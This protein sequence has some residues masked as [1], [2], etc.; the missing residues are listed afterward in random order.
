[1]IVS[2]N[3]LADYVDLPKDPKELTERL[4]MAGL[5]HESTQPV[6]DDWAID[7]EVTSNRPD[8]MSHVGVA[9][10]IAALYQ[11]PLRL[12]EA[13][14]QAA[15]ASVQTMARVIVECPDLC[16]Q[17]V[18]RVIR[19]VT[20]G[21]SPTWLVKRLETMGVKSINNVVDITNY[22]LFE[23]G[24]PLHA[25]DFDKLHERTIRVR[26]GVRGE[27]ILAIDHRNYELDPQMCII[28]DS[29]RA[30]AIG[31]V[32]GGAETEVTYQTRNV[33]IEAAEFAPLSI[34]ATSRKLRLRTAS[35]ERFERGIDPEMVDWASRRCCALILEY[36]GGQLC[37]GAIHFRAT[38]PVRK[39]I[40]LRLNQLP[41]I[42]GIDIP[43]RDVQRILT[44]LGCREESSDNHGQL[45]YIA[46]SWRRDLQR[47]IDLI[48]EVARIYGY[49][50]IPETVAIPVRPA[51]R[52]D[53][54]RVLEKVR[55][56]LTAAGFHEAMTVSAIPE[57]WSDSFSPWTE[58]PALACQSPMI[59]GTDRLRR[60]LLPSLLAARS[61][62][63]S[64]GNELIELFETARV[65][66]PRDGSL[67]E[68]PLM[69]G[70]TSARGFHGV[71]G[72]LEAVLE[73]LHIAQPLVAEELHDPF[74]EPGTGFRLQLGQEPWAV[75]GVTAPTTNRRFGL[76][77]SSTVAEWRFS[78]LVA[79]AKLVPQY[80]PIVPYPAIEQDLNL[81]VDE[82]VRWADLL[83][84]I[85]KAG[86]AL[87]EAV[88]YRET[89]RD[90][91]SDGPN[92]KRILLRLTLR[93]HQGTLTTEQANAVREEVVRAAAADCD[94]K[95]LGS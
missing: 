94:A 88:T 82:S 52:T 10:E 47:E 68:E 45:C 62:N 29:R 85:R 49:D 93:S 55:R 66:L 24:Q 80:V 95:L 71:K 63:E 64:V 19:G 53:T 83:Q 67:P 32:M 23:C 92:K 12:P 9:R 58:Q 6:G 26:R 57:I 74:F 70:I 17:Y 61:Y 81:I 2:W 91:H 8:W 1:M 41:R 42:L 15:A 90:P 36:A 7:L 3:W 39:S 48:E 38:R 43:K 33:L 16:P 86:G 20:I 34:R 18:A 44:A 27:Q 59:K 54:D 60:S 5:N 13:S 51:P 76:R 89:Y 77:R 72:I 73:E 84:S 69:I 65:Y 46:P 79:L 22:V 40:V 21:P 78:P 56:V 11:Q 35:S 31:G 4:A 75:I 25:F 28:A 14:P 50:K 87:I 37:E 30:V